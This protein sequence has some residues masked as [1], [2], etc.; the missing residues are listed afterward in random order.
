[1]GGWVGVRMNGV[2]GGTGVIAGFYY[3]KQ[4]AFTQQKD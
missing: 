4:S 2:R 1:M 3:Y